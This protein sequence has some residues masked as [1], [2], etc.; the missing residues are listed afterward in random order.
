M[1]VRRNTTIAA[2]AQMVVV[3][4]AGEE[5][6]A[7][8]TAERARELGRPL[9]AVPGPLGSAASLGTN[10]LI[11]SGSA[12]ALLS[13]KAVLDLLGLAA[14]AALPS[15]AEPILEA[16]SAGALDADA[17]RRRV[18]ISDGELA[19]RLLRLTLAALRGNT[20]SRASA[21]PASSSRQLLLGRFVHPRVV[22]FGSGTPRSVARKAGSILSSDVSKTCWLLRSIWLKF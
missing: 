4:E 3:V 22:H 11:A 2:L 8:I 9:F 21:K 7:L 16:L 18:R 1:F 12:R 14:P 5:S 6:G 20:A 19:E 15:R 17:L 13:A 10:A